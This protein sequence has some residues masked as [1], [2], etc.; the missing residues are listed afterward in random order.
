M[1]IEE[2]TKIIDN[3][4]ELQKKNNLSIRANECVKELFTNE[5]KIK[6]PFRNIW[7]IL[8]ELGPQLENPIKKTMID[9]HV[10][11]KNIFRLI[12]G[13]QTLLFVRVV[14]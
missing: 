5:H 10:N 11:P 13:H 6:G 3:K 14:L 9:L 4:H 2:V 12:V 7:K 8:F 1:T